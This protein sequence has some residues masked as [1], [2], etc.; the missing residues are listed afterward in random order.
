MTKKT[1]V[2]IAA[3]VLTLGG[4]AGTLFLMPDLL[5]GFIRLH[6]AQSTEAKKTESSK[7]VGHE[8]E[9]DLDLFVVNLI[10]D[11]PARYLRTTL[12]FGVASEHEKEEVKK[13]NG[14]IRHAIIMYLTERRVEELLTPEG[15]SRVRA[16]VH[17]AI[18][19]AVGKK[20]VSN[21]YF[22]EFLIQ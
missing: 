11:G 4:G 20:L 22:K 3:A 7:K 9:A 1:V 2:I 19:A 10:A 17:K 18:N 13:F 5:P 21:V 14:V 15:K 12:S 6:D 16:D 8:V